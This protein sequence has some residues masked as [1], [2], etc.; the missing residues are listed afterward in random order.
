MSATIAITLISAKR[1]FVK[2]V[3]ERLQ[4]VLFEHICRGTIGGL[5]DIVDR[6]W[7]PRISVSLAES[8]SGARKIFRAMTQRHDASD[9]ISPSGHD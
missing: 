9:V 4:S 5:R 2:N 3:P 1:R 6:R 8:I 7:H